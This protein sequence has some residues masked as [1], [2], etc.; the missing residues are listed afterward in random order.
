MAPKQSRKY[1]AAK[2]IKAV[3]IFKKQNKIF[4]FSSKINSLQ[5]F[6]EKQTRRKKNSKKQNPTE[7]KKKNT[8]DKEKLF[9]HIINLKNNTFAI[10]YV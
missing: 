9:T 8:D 5:S 2:N 6:K 7:T 3:L 4:G 1:I 10:F